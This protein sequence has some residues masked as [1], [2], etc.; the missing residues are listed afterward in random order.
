MR[1]VF[2]FNFLINQKYKNYFVGAIF[3]LDIL[4]TNRR[5]QNP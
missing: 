4:T 3:F 1:I 2:L 5:A